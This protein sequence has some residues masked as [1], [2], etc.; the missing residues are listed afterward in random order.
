[1]VGKILKPSTSSVLCFYIEEIDDM[2]LCTINDSCMRVT[3][4]DGKVFDNQKIA[5]D[6][7]KSFITLT[8]ED[9]APIVY[10]LVYNNTCL[11]FNHPDYPGETSVEYTNESGL[12][13]RYSNSLIIPKT[14]RAHAIYPLAML[15]EEL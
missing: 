8:S 12:L 15:L 13:V 10:P 7:M 1:M 6:V 11:I 2:L 5:L 4:L 14:L 9:Y 3:T